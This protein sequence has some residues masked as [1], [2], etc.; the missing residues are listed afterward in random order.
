MTSR[1]RAMI[2]VQTIRL[3]LGPAAKYINRSRYKA[4]QNVTKKQHRPPTHS[5]V[6]LSPIAISK[7]I[8]PPK[9]SLSVPMVCARHR[10][11]QTAQPSADEMRGDEKRWA[12]V[13]GLDKRHRWGG[14]NGR[15]S[16]RTKGLARLGIR[17]HGRGEIWTGAGPVRGG[18]QKVGRSLSMA[19]D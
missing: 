15:L 13:I 1:M 9:H 12:A 10:E 16:V 2:L 3:S 7:A 4:V 8:H 17:G 6:G 18:G 11:P 19:V 14:S 5:T